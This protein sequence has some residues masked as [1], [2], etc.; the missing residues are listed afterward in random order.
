MTAYLTQQALQL[1]EA[2][3]L[4]NSPVMQRVRAQI[5]LVAL[6]AASVIITGP[7]GS[8]KEC[9]A[10]AL[11]LCGPRQ[12][13]PFVAVNCGAI[14]RDLIESE[15]FGHERGSF[16][17]ASASREGRFE[18]ANGGTLFLDEIGDMPVDM[19][20]RLLRVIE[21]RAVQ[22]VG[23]NRSIPV[24]VRVV[25]AT[26]HDLDIAITERRFREDLFYRLAVVLIALPPLS[27]RPE[28]IAS[29]IAHFVE[30]L[31]PGRL[32][33]SSAAL[34]RLAVH[35]WPGNVRELRNLVERAVIL[36]PGE[37]IDE[38]II[39][40]LLDSRRRLGSSTPLGKVPTQTIITAPIDLTAEL[41][42]IESAYISEAL[43]RSGGVVAAT[44]R[45]LGLRRTTLVEKMRRHDLGRC[46]SVPLAAAA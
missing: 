7:S 36:H 19:Q 18:Q 17:G 15:L 4:G 43:S 40:S 8:G 30:R 35:N 37:L 46:E 1:V 45:L 42:R 9:V 44:A 27:E 21:D 3:I 31:A 22:R 32:K 10:R 28:D 11:H 12:D 14:P 23:S 6:E 25:S 34:N 29:L 16:T 39:E 38:K 26:H 2:T 33:L 20:V 5:S 13:K 24:D 41:A